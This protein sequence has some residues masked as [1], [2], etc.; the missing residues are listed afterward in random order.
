MPPKS[1]QAKLAEPIGQTYSWLTITGFVE[2]LPNG[3]R[4][5]RCRCECGNEVEATWN[6]LKTSMRKSCGCKNPPKGMANRHKDLAGKRFGKLV[7]LQLSEHKL[8]ESVRW[9]CQCDCGSPPKAILS[10]ALT[11][12][13]KSCGNCHLFDGETEKLPPTKRRER[14]YIGEYMRRYRLRKQLNT[15]N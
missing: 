13:Q 11:D 9:V 5:Y 15:K 3:H 4:L 2:Q 1:S 14:E 6:A 8:G 7:A 10:G 12:G